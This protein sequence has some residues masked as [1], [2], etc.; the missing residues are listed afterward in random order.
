LKHPIGAYYPGV[1]AAIQ[2]RE[3]RI[4]AIHRTFLA[5]EGL[6]KAKVEPAKAA[7]GPIHGGAVR[8]APADDVLGLAEGI[9][10]ALSVQQAIVIPVWATWGTANLSRIELPDGV[11]E[12]VI[13]AD[14]DENGAGERTA[15][16]AARRFMREGRR[17]RV[18]R[19]PKAAKDF[20]DVRV[21]AES[22][23]SSAAVGVPNKVGRER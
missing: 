20:N 23:K 18:A 9:E 16:E 19:P 13:C 5:P 22:E 12:I 2:D 11:R 6:G 4:V 10:T 1:V 7:L 15:I 8:L 17:V 14:N 3:R 21:A